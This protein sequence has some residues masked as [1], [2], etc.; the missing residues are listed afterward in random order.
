M[1][2]S[3]MVGHLADGN[4]QDRIV[5]A[6]MVKHVS[7]PFGI[8]DRLNA[9]GAALAHRVMTDRGDAETRGSWRPPRYLVGSSSRRV[10][11]KCFSV[12]SGPRI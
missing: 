2:E 1:L 10:A 7:H 9:E 11:R 4:P 12:R 3:V 6:G 8:L 5:V